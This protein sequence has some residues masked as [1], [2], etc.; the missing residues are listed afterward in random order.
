MHRNDDGRA[1]ALRRSTAG[2]NTV[3]RVVTATVLAITCILTTS[4][5]TDSAG[6]QDAAT[7]GPIVSTAP[8]AG[9]AA[10]SDPAAS[11]EE[12]VHMVQS[13]TGKC[14]AAKRQPLNQPIGSQFDTDMAKLLAPHLADWARCESYEIKEIYL[15]KPGGLAAFQRDWSKTPRA[16][17]GKPPALYFQSVLPTYLGFGNNYAIAT[18]PLTTT[19]FKRLNLRYLRCDEV[20]ELNAEKIPSD[21]DGCVFSN[22]S[23]DPAVDH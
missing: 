19:Q 18:L 21:A 23:G 12:L 5:T 17:S 6:R 11:L 13:R 15:F 7:P 1:P 10:L 8:T 22:V 16:N 9:S 2:S 3:R 4:C 20:T 14:A